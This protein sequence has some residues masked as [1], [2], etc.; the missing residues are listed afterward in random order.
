MGIKWCDFVVWTEARKDNMSI[1]RIEFDESFWE[2]ELLPKLKYFCTE[3]VVPEIVTRQLQK[4]KLKS[5]EA[6]IDSMDFNVLF[7]VYLKKTVHTCMY[8]C[9]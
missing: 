6:L 7:A 5:A 9:I 3:E 2:T 1:Q 4:Q 8:A